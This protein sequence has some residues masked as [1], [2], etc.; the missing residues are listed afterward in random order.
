M[1]LI[2][3]EK[4]SV[5][6][7]IATAISANHDE[8]GCLVNETWAVTWAAGHLVDLA[9]PQ[10]YDGWKGSWQE[11]PLPMLPEKWKWKVSTSARERFRVVAALMRDP[12]FDEVVNACDPDREGEGIFTRIYAHAGCKLPVTRLWSSS[13]E[14][15]AIRADLDARKPASETAGLAAASEGRAKAD[16]LVGMNATRAATLSAGST[17]NLGRVQTPTLAMVVKRTDEAENFTAKPFWRT[18]A[19]MDNS[20]KL[21]GPKRDDAACAARDAD[22]ARA[23]LVVAEVKRGK[24]T[25]KPPLLFNLNDLQAEASRILGM[26]AAET[27]EALEE[28]YLKKLVSYPRTESRYIGSAD[29]TTV[30][31]IAQ[32]AASLPQFTAAAAKADANPHNADKLANDAKVTGHAALTPLA[33]A[34]D[35]PKT[36]SLPK[37]QAGLLLLVQGRLLAA[38]SAPHEAATVKVV[39]DANGTSFEASASTVTQPGWKAVEEVVRATY[40][41]K[42]DEKSGQIIPDDVTQG[43]TLAPV[44]IDVTEGKT[45]PPALFTDATLLKAMETCGKDVEDKALRDALTK[46]ETHATGLG[47]PAT[48]ASII[49]RLVSRGFCERVKKVEIRATDKGRR[50]VARAPQTLLSPELTGSMEEKLARIEAADATHTDDMLEKFLEEMEKYTMET[51]NEINA[52]TAKTIK[53]NSPGACPICGHP[54]VEKGKLWECSTN[55]TSGKEGGYARIAGCGFKVW[56]RIANHDLTAD[57]FKTLLSG[58]ETAPIKMKSKTGNEFEACLKLVDDGQGSKD[59]KFVFKNEEFGKCPRCGQQIVKS[60]PIWKCSSNKSEKTEN[61]WEDVAG[62][63]FMIGKQVCGHF[64]TDVEVKKLLE[65]GEVFVE[66]MVGKSGKPFDAFVLLDGDNK[67][68]T[69]LDFSRK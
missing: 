9:D 16:W 66:G 53:E 34:F 51:V 32:R 69:K 35:A 58:Q 4:A 57:E 19:N 43:Q 39:A 3:A 31:A 18:V 26:S 29:V 67:W 11:V 5:A 28:L 20:W 1:K 7:E 55:K 25:A 48:R 2:V 38:V 68:G 40:G 61:G 45:K 65:N 59:V 8:G 27:L 52:N 46:S 17:V 23:G 56:K 60:G 14:A 49:E 50:V 22:A 63:G 33:A 62:C 30:E 36:T 44:S 64:W 54:I 42:A 6:R 15:A 24:K 37:E 47:T 41:K 13:L 10:G 12:R 21:E